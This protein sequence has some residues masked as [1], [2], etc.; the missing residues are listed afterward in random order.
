M[1]DGNFHSCSVLVA[2]ELPLPAN[3]PPDSY[4]C[5]SCYMLVAVSISLLVT[6]GHAGIGL[7]TL[8]RAQYMQV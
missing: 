1:M 8:I 7:T 2:D 6:C 4:M 5:D 3:F